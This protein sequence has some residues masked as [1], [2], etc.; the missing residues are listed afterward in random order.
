V[1]AACGG[2]PASD[3]EVVLPS[4]RAVGPQC[5]GGGPGG[6]TAPARL[7]APTGPEPV[8]PLFVD[9]ES[10]AAQ[11]ARRE[12]AHAA[13]IAAIVDRPLAFS[14]GDWLADV[15]GEV[16]RR[17]TAA[18][19]AGA[20]AIFMVY[21]IPHRDAGAGFS[22]GGVPG[23]DAYRGFTAQVT[24]GIG[25]ARAIVV[26]EPDSLGQMDTLPQQ[27]QDERYQLLRDAVD[28]YAR[29]PNTSVYLDGANCGWTA[30]P[31]MA[32]R[33]LR[34]GVSH[35]RGFA[36]NVANYHWTDD[37]VA[38]AENISALTGGAHFVVDTSR[39][40]RGPFSGDLPNQWCNPPD[41]GLGKPPTTETGSE[42][43][44]AF[45]WV[46]VPGSSDGECGRGN[47]PAGLWWQEQAEELVR[48][49]VG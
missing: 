4:L 15:R 17:A 42:F 23:A 48:N 47:P 32:Q 5:P 38:R 3:Q 13:N 45:L 21:A 30:A 9:T 46:K 27:E 40:G 35:A 28:A 26:L 6:A 2:E 29:L 24:E 14:V 33:L 18:K 34:A 16:G 44:D 11:H 41:R 20:T 19:N 8:E 7:A 37:E 39:N 36:V 31:D 10:Q 22:G 43:A 25:D 49:A 12:P 1:A